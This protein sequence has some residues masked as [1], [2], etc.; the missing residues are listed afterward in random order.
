MELDNKEVAQNG[1]ESAASL[2]WVGTLSGKVD[3][4]ARIWHEWVK[5]II[6]SA[7]I[8][9]KTVLSF[10]PNEEIH[11]QIETNESNKFT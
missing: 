6:Y 3:K 8:D 2:L 10:F 4:A 11:K 9:M 7:L 1:E 5:G